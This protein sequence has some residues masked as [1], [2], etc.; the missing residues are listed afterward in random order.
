MAGSCI[1]QPND[2]LLKAT[3]SQPENARAFF[4]NHLPKELAAALDW[5]SL[6]L[7]PCSFIDPQFASS[8][9]DLLFHITLQKRDAFVYLLFEHQSSEDPRMALRLLSYILRIWERFAQNNPPP[10]KLPAILPVVLAQGKRPWKTS[11]RLEDLIDLPP[12]VA[13]ILRPWQPTLAYHL[14]ELVRIPYEAIAGT[15]EGVLTLRAL[16]AEPM[17]ELLG[18]SVW[19]EALFLSISEGALERILRYIVNA[20]VTIPQLKERL[21][22]IQTKPL[23]SKTMTLADRLRQE[24][25]LEGKLEGER[26]GIRR[27]K[28]EGQLRAFRT[29]VLRALEIRHGAYPEG[30]RDAIESMED[31]NRLEALLESA[32]RSDSIETFAQKL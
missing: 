11:T 16:K 26:E 15:P 7:E 21:G 17:D 31:P 29:A 12:A 19:D 27:G 22:K 13:H 1:H 5:S 14:L 25:K 18:D 10:A 8:E 9:S 28:E 3:F 2:K 30:I 6:S 24:G 20:D 4:E 32:I 23:Q